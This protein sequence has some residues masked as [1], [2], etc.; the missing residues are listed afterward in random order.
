VEIRDR[1]C[2]GFSYLFLADGTYPSPYPRAGRGAAVVGVASASAIGDPNPSTGSRLGRLMASTRKCLAQSNKSPRAGTATKREAA[3]QQNGS[4]RGLRPQPGSREPTMMK[5]KT[6]EANEIRLYKAR[7]KEISARYY[8][9]HR[10]VIKL[11]MILDISM[12]QAR[13]IAREQVTQ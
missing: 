12:K 8:Q 5:P 7:R 2:A 3:R 1:N 4:S 6:D 10:K 13:A 11:A 9:R